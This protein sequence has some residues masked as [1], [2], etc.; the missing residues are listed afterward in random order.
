MIYTI[1]TTIGREESV[2]DS[3]RSK[4]A[5]KKIPVRSISRPPEIKGY[6]F[7]EGDAKAVNELVQGI[8]H[9]KGMIPRG[10][11][12]DAIEHFF[13]KKNTEIVLNP[14]DVVEIIGG[15]FKG[16]KGEVD[17]FDS[18]KAEV[19]IKLLEATIPIP[20]TL[21]SEIVKILRKE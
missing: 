5:A 12:I 4:A 19:T 11:E 1:R 8:P 2:I 18:A 13:E 7:I 10:M 21:S 14:G 15:P 20:V 6:L 3:L 16:E 9:A 17:R